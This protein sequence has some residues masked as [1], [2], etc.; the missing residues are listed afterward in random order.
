MGS[1]GTQIL[2]MKKAYHMEGVQLLLAP[3]SPALSSPP[4]QKENLQIWN[5]HHKMVHHVKFFKN[6]VQTFDFLLMTYAVKF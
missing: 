1:N 3:S 2:V 6:L 5:F 4:P